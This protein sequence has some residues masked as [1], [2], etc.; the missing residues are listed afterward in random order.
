MGRKK[1]GEGVVVMVEETPLG[2][3]YRRFRTGLGSPG[4]DL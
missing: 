1:S 2:S 4:L 3:N